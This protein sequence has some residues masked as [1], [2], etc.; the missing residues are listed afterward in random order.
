M[1]IGE[2]TEKF[3]KVYDIVLRAN[4]AALDAVKPGTA[5]E[6]IDKA[7]RQLITAEGYGENFIHRVGH[8]LGMD[9][10]EEPYLVSGN[11]TPLEVGMVFSDEPGIYI[12]GEF[13]VQH[14]RLGGC[15]SR[16][17]QAIERSDTNPDRD[18][19]SASGPSGE[20]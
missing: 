19:L 4:Q 10:H 15:H 13:G 17:R 3:R 11:K 8:G 12:E 6:D 7:A 14:R 5:C 1:F 20:D 9:V 18:G 16:G 2:P